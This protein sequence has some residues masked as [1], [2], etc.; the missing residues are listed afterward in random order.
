MA[1][2]GGNAGAKAP[3]G[4]DDDPLTVSVVT[5]GPGSHAFTKFGHDAIRVVDRRAGTDFVYNFGTF[6]FDSPRLIVDFL[7]G[8]LRY[9]LSRSRTP[10][11][12]YAY[13]RENRSIEIQDLALSPAEKRDLSLRLEENARPQNREYRYDYFRDNCST[14]VRDAL[15]GVMGGRLRPTALQPGTMSLRA[16]ALR[17]A[18]DNWPLYLGLLIVLG[19]STDRPIDQWAEA[20]L[21]EMLQRNLRGA[22]AGAAPLAGPLVK[23]ERVVFTAR[24]PAVRREPPLA[25]R[26]FVAWG[27]LRG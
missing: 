21:P 6:S 8:R 15:D 19:P 24:R 2:P 25:D 18:A 17:M 27:C 22:M 14:R 4:V 1:I 23:S 7:Q 20:F 13:R 3:A 12:E 10:A 9:W 5:F 16:H 26:F 11:T